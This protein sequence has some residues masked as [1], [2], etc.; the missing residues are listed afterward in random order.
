MFVKNRILSLI[1]IFSI[2]LSAISLC[3]CAD[4]EIAQAEAT[5]LSFAKAMGFIDESVSGNDA[6]SRADL[7]KLISKILLDK[8]ED[9]AVSQC[10]F[11]DV[12]DDVAFYVQTAVDAGIMNGCGNGIF[13]P[14]EPVTY[15]QLVKAMVCLLGRE[16]LAQSYGGYPAGYY[17]VAAELDIN[18]FAPPDINYQVTVDGVA[19]ILKLMIDC[20]VLYLNTDGRLET[21]GKT[22]LDYY[23][24][25]KYAIGVVEEFGSLNNNSE[26]GVDYVII[27]GTQYRCEETVFDSLEILGFCIDAYYKVDITGRNVI[28]Y[29]EKRANQTLTIQPED[30]VSVDEGGITYYDG[31]KE[32]TAKINM[33][34]AVIYNNEFVGSYTLATLNPFTVNKMDG[35]V[36]LINNDDDM[37][38]ETVKIKAYDTYI[39]SDI[40]NGVI[41]NKYHGDVTFNTRELPKNAIV[42]VFMQ[43]ISPDE[44][45]VD[46]V[47]SVMKNTYGDIINIIVTIESYSGT[48]NSLQYNAGKISE[49][50]IDGTVYKLAS[51]FEKSPNTN[52]FKI[53]DD[54]KIYFNPE[55]RISDIDSALD[56]YRIAYLIDETSRG[57]F[58]KLHFF[59]LLGT[60]GKILTVELPEKLKVEVGSSDKGM[61][62]ASTAVEYAGQTSGRIRRQP[63][64]YKLDSGKRIKW[65]R[66]IDENASATEDGFYKFPDIPNTSEY[67]LRANS[68]GG[69]LL[70]G[71]S[72]AIFC[73]PPEEER[74]NDEVYGLMLPGHI[75][76]GTNFDPFSAYGVEGYNPL[77]KVM[78]FE[79]TRNVATAP[80]K[81]SDIFVISNI[82]MFYDENVGEVAKV[83]GFIAGGKESVYLL[84]GLVTGLK[85]GDIIQ[86]GGKI[87]SVVQKINRVFYCDTRKMGEDNNG[88]PYT[89]PTNTTL[90]SD[91]RFVY[92]NVYYCDRS[93]ATL[94]VN[95]SIE[96]SYLLGSFK[97]VEVDTTGKEPVVAIGSV[98]AIKAERDY[99]SNASKVFIHTS[100]ITP[101][102]LVIYK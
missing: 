29:Y 92:G 37:H 7:A 80:S 94:K 90:Y 75:D 12:G 87:D 99:P 14:Y 54:V 91:N 49:I 41:Y 36:L 8:T 42:N 25:V 48:I 74:D 45:S 27:D 40:D 102:T 1:L 63:I 78:V 62:D 84:P 79:K 13:S 30:I 85:K 20:D 2:C 17:R 24:K 46:D 68:F 15:I 67:Y 72:T 16:Q 3:V 52:K 35:N 98:S 56:V 23:C 43:P 73:V 9:G 66:Y 100:A 10:A 95:G 28:F 18:A 65:I 51:S 83:E 89:N 57:T 93:S 22:F 47:I 69:H 101:K 34:T 31:E 61:V 4:E 88:T 71:V 33:D 64:L 77:A 32:C 39:I 97:I 96:L 53:G 70:I 55:G 86:L 60:N 81:Y 58:E 21:T 6:F 11:T 82:S 50:E 5:N 76:S 19:N 59:K 38:Y 26:T 44:L